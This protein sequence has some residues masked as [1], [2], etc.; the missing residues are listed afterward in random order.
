MICRKLSSLTDCFTV[1]AETNCSCYY[2]PVGYKTHKWSRL[3]RREGRLTDV[4][5]GSC[6]WFAVLLES[7]IT[8]CSTTSPVSTGM[9]D[10]LWEGIPPWYVTKPTRSTQ[11][12]IPLGLLDRAPAS[13]GWGRGV[14]VTS[15]G[16]QVTLC[17]HHTVWHVSCRSGDACWVTARHVC[18][19]FCSMVSVCVCLCV[20]T[21]VNTLK[22]AQLMKMQFRASLVLVG[23]HNH[24]LHRSTYW[25]HLANVIESWHA[26]WQCGLSLLFL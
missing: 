8:S 4:I 2:F 9:D 25:R 5:L 22:T 16:W 23:S 14:N 17:N 6:R 21:A 11:P 13:V 12:Y 26:R 18:L 10:H 20:A 19:H 24:V 3:R 7:F 1:L 15:A